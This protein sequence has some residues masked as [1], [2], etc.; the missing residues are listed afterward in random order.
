MSREFQT[1][2]DKITNELLYLGYDLS[3]VGTRYLIECIYII[4]KDDLI[5]DINLKSKIYPILSKKYKKEVNNIKCSI[6]YSTTVMYQ[7]CQNVKLKKY[8]C[9]NDSVKPSSKLVVY[10]VLNKVI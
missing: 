7:R 6:N 10:T 8:F 5:D 3:L 2:K 4:I 9:F 1:I